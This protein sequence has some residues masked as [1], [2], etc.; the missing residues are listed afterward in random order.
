MDVSDLLAVDVVLSD[1]AARDKADLLRQLAA[2]AAPRVGRPE[3]DVLDALRAREQL[4]STA[5]SKGLALPHARIEGVPPFILMARLRRAIDYEARDD[6][7]VD[8]V[9]LVLWPVEAPEGFLPALSALCRVL[10]QPGVARR[11]RD[12]GS[13][14]AAAAVL[15]RSDTLRETV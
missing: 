15:R 4:G 13:A 3:R 5:L 8:L 12:A 14:E 9:F 1:V 10:R 7:P 6:E 2:V 11:L